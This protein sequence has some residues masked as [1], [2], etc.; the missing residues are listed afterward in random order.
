MAVELRN[1]LS[2]ASG[3]RLPAT[4][5]FDYPTPRALARR[6]QDDLVGQLPQL[7]VASPC[8]CAERAGRADRDH[9]DELPLS[10]GCGYA[11][12]AVGF[13]QRGGDAISDFP[14]D[15]GWDV[16]VAVRP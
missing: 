10:W 12:G 5:L 11:G 8:L 15:R 6:L 9:C 3:L 1:R 4:L 2:A 7:V 16:E 13:A 14:A